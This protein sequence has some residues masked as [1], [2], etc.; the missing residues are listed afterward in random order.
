MT[1]SIRILHHAK[2]NNWVS[3][4]VSGEKVGVAVSKNVGT[5]KVPN[6]VWDFYPTSRTAR[7]ETGTGDLRG[8][9]NERYSK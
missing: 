1:S 4:F 2:N 9:L 6:S 5:Q 3:C 7:I 8:F